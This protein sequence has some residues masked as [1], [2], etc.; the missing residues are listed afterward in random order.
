MAGAGIKRL[1]LVV[2]SGPYQ[3]RSARDQLD[4]ALAAAALE[5][6]LE[7]FF[8]GP[9]SLQL[10]ESH[11][12]ETAGFPRG[13]RGWRSLPALTTVHAWVEDG[14]AARLSAAGEPPLLLD[15][16]ELGAAAMAERIADCDWVWVV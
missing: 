5:H 10:L 3:G 9:G 8:L 2:R 4:I 6:S 1:A 11:Q 13:A 15:V 12:P 16:E 7:L 14:E